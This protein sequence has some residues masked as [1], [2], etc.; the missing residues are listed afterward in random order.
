MV[1]AS[2]RSLPAFTCGSTA[3]TLANIM[4]TSPA[5]SAVVA[6]APPL[7]GTWTTFTPA[8]TLNISPAMWKP[9][10]LLAEA[11]LSLPGCALASAI[12]SSTF[13]AGTAGFT[14]S[15]NGPVASMLTGSKS[16]TVS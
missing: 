16:L 10:P 15:T 9:L 2:A 8:M 7:Y 3:A 12:S 1:T 14:T 4:S 5:S 13:F 6:G 11:K